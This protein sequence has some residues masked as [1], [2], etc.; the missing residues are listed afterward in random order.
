MCPPQSRSVRRGDGSRYFPVHTCGYQT[1]RLVSCVRLE[2][3]LLRRREE[4]LKGHLETVPRSPGGTLQKGK[5]DLFLFG[6]KQQNTRRT[7]WGGQLG[8]GREF[9]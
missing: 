2:L 5:G 9:R 8:P 4:Q 3:S 7:V 6:K 1:Q